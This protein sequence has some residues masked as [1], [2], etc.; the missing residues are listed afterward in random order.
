MEQKRTTNKARDIAIG[1]FGWVILSNLAIFLLMYSPMN[2]DVIYI[3]LG[4]WLFAIITIAVLFLKKR[5]WLGVGVVAVVIINTIL[6][7]GL[8]FVSFVTLE[9]AIVLSGFPLPLSAGFFL[10]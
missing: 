5:I 3:S 7:I 4:M 2:I 1:F 9:G 8:F 6:W 10:R